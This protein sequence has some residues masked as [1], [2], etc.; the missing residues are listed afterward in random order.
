MDDQKP[1][2]EELESLLDAVGQGDFRARDRLVDMIHRELRVMAHQAL[3]REHQRDPLMQTTVLVNESYLKL[4]GERSI[5]WKSKEHFFGAARLAMRQFLIDWAR[6]RKG[7]K[8]GGGQSLVTLGEWIPESSG[9]VIDAMALSEAL[10]RLARLDPR[11]A[12][13]VEYKCLLGLSNEETAQ[14]LKVSPR[15]VV[16]DWTHA[17][18]W[19][20]LQLVQN[21]T[22]VDD[23]DGAS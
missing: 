18:A 9:N 22:R 13:V 10:T 11:Q 14:L 19:L 23:N 3:A 7:L 20:K 5:E 6:R 12:E 4:F 17:K 15:T 21:L 16:S 1:A 8:R 2:H